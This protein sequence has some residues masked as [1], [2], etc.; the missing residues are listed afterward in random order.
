M[1]VNYMNIIKY[2]TQDVNVVQYTLCK[3]GYYDTHRY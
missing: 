2:L 3:G 1:E